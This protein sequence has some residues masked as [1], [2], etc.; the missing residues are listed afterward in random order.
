[1]V[2]WRKKDRFF[3]YLMILPT[4]IVL[5]LFTIYPFIRSIYLSLYVTNNMG[6]PG[7]FVGLKNFQRVFNSK[8]FNRSL[9]TTLKFAAIVGFGTFLV[10]MILAL[11]SINAGKGSKVYQTMYAIP[12]AIA[13]VP[14]AALAT[15][16]FANNGIL[17][18][19]LGTNI[20]FLS[21]KDTALWTVAIVQIWSEVGTSFIF[22]LVG[23]RN[24]SEDLVEAATL[25]GANML[26]KIANVYIPMA[27]PQISF[28][29]FLN[30]MN[31]FK[32]F[33]IIKML[34][35]K[36]PGNSTDILS[37]EVYSNAFLRGRFETACVYSL[38]LCGFIFFFTR[39]Q[40]FCEKRLVHYQ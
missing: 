26:Q 21:R 11:L 15:Y 31:G 39:I 20:E 38:V 36:G 30:I 8:D 17:N 18:H 1:M 6:V 25:D 23:F 12:I 4:I 9:M 13:S 37:Y 33:A 7:T 34:T 22:L 40:Q 35:Q 24:V 32:G 14:T 19:V 29:I 16:I 27:S 2:N 10:G 5:V 3:P 28:V